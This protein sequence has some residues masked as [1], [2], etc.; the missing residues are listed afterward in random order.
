[1]LAYCAASAA[2]EDRENMKNYV[3]EVMEKA[4]PLVE[5][6]F[7]ENNILF[8]PSAANF[9]LFR[10]AYAQRVWTLLAESG[11][12][13]R[14]QNKKNIRGTLRVTIGAV[15]QMKKFIKIYQ[16]KIIRYYE[17]TNRNH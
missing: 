1:M 14:E 6:F 13:T 10:P 17:K 9:I 16:T 2:F 5:K 3:E 8:E 4:K 7:T 12:L 15:K 11:V